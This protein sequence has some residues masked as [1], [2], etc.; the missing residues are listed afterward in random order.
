MFENRK[1]GRGKVRGTGELMAATG[2]S[3]PQA[4]SQIELT[5]STEGLTAI[6]HPSYLETISGSTGFSYYVIEI[7]PPGLPDYVIG[8][9]D[10]K[11]KKIFLVRKNIAAMYAHML[12]EGT[13]DQAKQKIEGL[14]IHEGGHHA[15][16]VKA[17]EKLIKEVLGKPELEPQELQEFFNDPS[18]QNKTRELFWKAFWFDL[19]NASLDIWLEAYQARGEFAES[20]GKSLMV[21]NDASVKG[22]DF[23]TK[24]P[25]HHQ[26]AQWLV[27]EEGY[28]KKDQRRGKTASRLKDELEEVDERLL[29]P[30]VSRAVR[31]LREAGVH[32]ALVNTN[33]FT[34][35]GSDTPEVKARAINQ[36]FQCV[37]D[38]ICPI[39]R[40]LLLVEFERRKAEFKESVKTEKPP[41]TIE[42]MQAAFHKILKILLDETQ[43]AGQKAFASGTP[44]QEEQQG[45]QKIFEK[46]IQKGGSGKGDTPSQPSPQ[47]SAL[48]KARQEINAAFEESE[49]KR[50]AELA[51][52]HEVSEAS[53]SRLEEIRRE[54]HAEIAWLTKELAKIFIN[55]RRTKMKYQVIEGPIRPGMEGI[56]IA[57]TLAGNPEPKTRQ[58]VEKT[59]QFLET[60]IEHLFDTSG[61]MQGERLKYSQIVSVIITTA[62]ENVKKLLNAQGLLRQE[63]N[64]RE[65]PLRTGFV[66][67]TTAPERIKKLDEPT[68]PNALAQMI[69]QTGRHSGGTDDA[70]AIQALNTDF[71]LR[72]GN[73][74]KF[75]AVYSDGEGNPQAVQNILS[76]I[77][78]DNSI[79][80]LVVAMGTQVEHVLQTYESPARAK[81][82]T[83]VF[84]VQGDDIRG[85]VHKLGTYLVK[86]AQ[87][88]VNGMR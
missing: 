37:V 45:I 78:K 58:K 19:G 88:A 24:I 52:R 63:R 29:S 39:W 79:T 80:V 5:L 1:T 49:R 23:L 71:K 9:T 60:E 16:E 25:L 77:E 10:Q 6:I 26:L 28:Y 32:R 4:V 3:N 35:W 36:K 31:K 70:A 57:E 87:E 50:I 17:L 7:P 83:N 13:Q 8:F 47:P 38:H 41:L 12:R 18:D 51:G 54:Y 66:L 43:E 84:V 73:T 20:F 76:T 14:L 55:Q 30:E 44:S 65:N 46:I 2:P 34:Y 42:E 72:R 59:T 22:R 27:G 74:L 68:K 61:S 67:F 69:E 48:D 82:A 40:K 81:G 85:N 11:S 15:P 64:K 86:R 21:L 33:A 53:Q 75:M 56:D 62:F